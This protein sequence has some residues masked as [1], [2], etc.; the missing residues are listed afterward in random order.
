MYVYNWITCYIPENNMTLYINSTSIKLKKFKV[1]FTH[2]KIYKV[3]SSVL[4]SIPTELCNLTSISLNS[5]TFLSP[6]KDKNLSLGFP[7]WLGGEESACQCRRHRF[8]PWSEKIPYAPEQLSPC[9]T[10]IEPVLWSSGDATAEPMLHG[11]RSHCN[12]RPV[13]H[14]QKRSPHSNED[15][16]QPKINTFI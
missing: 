16:T 5:R 4:L 13:H 12:E 6:Q 8:D 2:H 7:W 3:Y 11:R 14:D 15:P 10:T 1:E 9:T